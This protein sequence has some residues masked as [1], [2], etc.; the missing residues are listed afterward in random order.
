MKLIED[1]PRIRRIKGFAL[2]SFFIVIIIM[3]PFYDESQ[4]RPFSTFYTILAGFGVLWIIANIFL[5]Y[6]IVPFKLLEI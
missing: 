6:F 3:L 2:I 1:S 5:N 4:E